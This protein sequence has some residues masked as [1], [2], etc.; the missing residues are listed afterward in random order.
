NQSIPLQS[1]RIENDFKAWYDIMR[2]LSHMFGLEYSLSDLDERSDELINSMSA[3]IDELEQ[4]LP[5]L[6]VKAYIEEVTGDFTETSFMPLGDVW[7][8]ELGDLFEDLE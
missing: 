7:K 2:R 1:L 6:N 5:Q 8:R 3:K 4:K